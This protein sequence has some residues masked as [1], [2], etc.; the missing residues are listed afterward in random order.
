MCGIAGFFSRHGDPEAL[1]RAAQKLRHRG[2]DGE[3]FFF[4]PPVG[5][6]HRRLSVIDLSEAAAQPFFSA[7]RTH[8]VVFNGEIYN[9]RELAREMDYV[10]RTRSDTEILLEAFRRRGR[11]ALLQYNGIFAFAVWDGRKLFLARDP[12][13]VKPLVYAYDGQNFYFASELKALLELISSP[14]L[15]IEALCDYMF[16]EYVPGPATIF[17][18]VYKLMPGAWLEVSEQGLTTGTYYDVIA[19]A[20]AGAFEQK[21]GP[22]RFKAALERSVH[23]QQTADVPLGA[24]LSGGTDSSLLVA[25][26]QEQNAEPVRTFTIG[27]DVSSHDESAYAEAVAGKLGTRHTLTR[28]TEDEA[29]AWAEKI[30][31]AYDEPFAVSSCIPMLLLSQTTRRHVTVAFSGDG[32]DELFMGYGYYDWHRRIETMLRVGGWAAPALVRTALSFGGDRF[33]NAAETLDLPRDPSWWIRVWSRRQGMF[34]EKEIGRLLRLDY[35]HR[36]LTHDWERLLSLR[37]HP[38]ERISLFDVRRY[39]AEDLMYKTD[40]ASM[41]YGLE[42]RVP[43]LDVEVAEAALCLPLALRRDGSKAK[44]LMKAML[45]ERLPRELVHRKKWGFPAPTA[46]WL[47]GKLAPLLERYLDPQRLRAQGIFHSAAVGEYVRR[48]RAGERR[49]HS[50]LWN[51]L[52]FQMWHER[53]VV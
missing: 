31:E 30:V 7:D 47:S 14:G 23:L 2:P 28:V 42:V 43:Y 6:A 29:L 26:F 41:H 36:T 52:V 51:L 13:G 5:L 38:F 40:I 11:D 37:M 33:K 25:L 53:Y 17:E 16:L 19:R 32:G 21:S 35:V 1:K 46:Q 18:G 45:E 49:L 27:F 12:M 34:S 20:Q 48:F 3:G 50:R 44:V 39:L 22:E 15:N 9:Y 8:V 10:P 4:D 24:F